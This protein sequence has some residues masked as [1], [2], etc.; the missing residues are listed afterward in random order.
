MTS[1]L[2]DS[3]VCVC[4]HLYYT[5]DAAL[6]LGCGNGSDS[7]MVITTNQVSSDTH[8]CLELIGPH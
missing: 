3:Q 5:F 7:D 4:M 2:S 6:T 1:L 8:L